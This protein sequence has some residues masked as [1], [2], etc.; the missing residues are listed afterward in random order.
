M[1]PVSDGVAGFDEQAKSGF[2]RIGREFRIRLVA[3]IGRKLP[4]AD[5]HH[6]PAE[7]TVVA[8][9]SGSSRPGVVVRILW[10]KVG[11]RRNLPLRVRRV[12]RSIP[13]RNLSFIPNFVDER[14]CHQDT[15]ALRCRPGR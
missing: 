14:Q 5:T 2:H 4:V 3:W 9:A 10:A 12:S 15:G 11:C 8:R 13:N 7:V 1:S 6:W